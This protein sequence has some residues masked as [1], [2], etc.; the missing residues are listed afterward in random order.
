MCFIKC[1]NCLLSPIPEGCRTS[2]EDGDMRG[3]P[4]FASLLL[5]EAV[6]EGVGVVS[7]EQARFKMQDTTWGRSIVASCSISPQNLHLP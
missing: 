6:D 5:G 3:S 4:P 1:C 7:C 2:S